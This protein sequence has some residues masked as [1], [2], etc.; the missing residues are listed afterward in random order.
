MGNIQVELTARYIRESK[1]WG[2]LPKKN[3]YDSHRVGDGSL[4]G[5]DWRIIIYSPSNIIMLDDIKIKI[6]GNGIEL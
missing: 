6:D 2:D 3:V 5:K 1:H 4:S